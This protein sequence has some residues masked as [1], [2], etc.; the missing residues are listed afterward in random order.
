MTEALPPSTETLPYETVLASQFREHRQCSKFAGKVAMVGFG[1]MGALHATILK[2]L[3]PESTITAVDESKLVRAGGS[4]FLKGVRFYGD[5]DKMLAKEHPDAAYVTAPAFAHYDLLSKLADSSIGSLFVE[6]PPTKDSMQLSRLV[7]SVGRRSVV[8]VGLQKRFALPFR[9]LKHLIDTGVLG[10]VQA[11]EA[12]IKSGD[13]L[14]ETTRF[15]AL[16]RGCM[17]DLGIHVVDLINW[18]FAGVNVVR[19]SASSIFTHLDDAV[20]VQFRDERGTDIILDVSWSSKD[21]R[22]PSAKVRIVAS[23]AVVEASEDML[24]V[25][26]IGGEE[27]I[28]SKPAY[29]GDSTA[30]NLADPEYTYEDMHFLCC[31]NAGREPETSLRACKSTMTLID[32]IYSKIQIGHSDTSRR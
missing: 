25:R 9:H 27:R 18:L 1:K 20:N 19:V 11:V 12:S 8:M 30:V 10:T 4:T 22:W 13:V 31:V 24:S 16:G 17:L 14:S 26:P 6:K 29:Y 2:M 23:D 15:D 28:I 21:V 5:L 3:N 32:E 7:D